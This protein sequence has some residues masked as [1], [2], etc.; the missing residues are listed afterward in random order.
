MGK[1]LHQIDDENSPSR[2]REEPS[3]LICSASRMVELCPISSRC[4]FAMLLPP[5]QSAR[6]T[7][8]RNRRVRVRRV[9]GDHD[10]RYLCTTS[11]PQYGQSRQSVRIGQEPVLRSGAGGLNGCHTFPAARTATLTTSLTTGGIT[12]RN[13]LF[14]PANL[15]TQSIR[16]QAGNTRL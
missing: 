9:R 16:P 7:Q 8:S 4:N 3:F 11:H 2:F 1:G 15:R 14:T 10:L 12:K 13:C 6:H 5:T